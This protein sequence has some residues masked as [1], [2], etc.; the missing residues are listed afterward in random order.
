MRD[1]DIQ[2]PH[3][4]DFAKERRSKSK[5]KKEERE[6]GGGD[7]REKGSGLPLHNNTRRCIAC[8]PVVASFDEASGKT[9]RLPQRR[10]QNSGCLRKTTFRE[11]AVEA[12]RRREKRRKKN[13]RALPDVIFDDKK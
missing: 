3:F 2:F 5:R 7:E 6:R 8:I 11:F 4:V 9:S 10:I 1:S 12:S 13:A